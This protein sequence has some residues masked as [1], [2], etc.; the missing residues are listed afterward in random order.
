[1]ISTNTPLTLKDL[2]LPPAGKIG[3]PW[4]EQVKT[5]PDRMSDGSEWPLIS[6]VTPSYNQGQ[7]IEETIRSILLQGYPNL[8][9]IIIDGCSNDGSV[10]IIKKY[11]QFLNYWISEPDDGQAHAIN[12]GLDKCSGKI[13]NW[14]NSDDFLEQSALEKIAENIRDF[15]IVAGGVKNFFEMQ[16]SSESVFNK[17]ITIKGMVGACENTS[18]H[19]P[20]VWLRLNVLRACGKINENFHF[21]FDAEL[22]IRVLMKTTNIRYIDDVLVNFRLHESSKTVSSFSGQ[23]RFIGDRIIFLKNFLELDEYTDVHPYIRV[24]LRNIEWRNA[25]WNISSDN[26]TP[27]WIK[28]I[29]ILSLILKDPLIRFNRMTLGTLRRS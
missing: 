23:D 24:G 16:K 21:N 9:Y 15:D 26:S 10:E 2:P 29:Q 13:F 14:I 3:W 22:T 8:E 17:N 25:L 18:Y 4:T 27:N 20:G 11:E 6:I 5:I 12:K 1:M 28:K 7:Y 19:Q